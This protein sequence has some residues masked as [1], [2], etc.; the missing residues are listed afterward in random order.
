MDSCGLSWNVDYEPL[1][2]GTGLSVDS[3]KALVRADTRTILGVA[4][5]D[6]RAVQ[7]HE[8]FSLVETLC[9][10]YSAEFVYGRAIDGGKQAVVEARIP[11][12]IEPKKGDIVEQRI[13]VYNAHDYSCAYLG[14]YTLLRLVCI[15][16]MTRSEA[17]SSFRIRHTS[18]LD[19]RL[20]SAIQIM[21]K[22]VAYFASYAEKCKVLAQKIVDKKMVEKFLDEVIGTP[23]VTDPETGEVRHSVRIENKRKEVVNLFQNGSGNEGET[24]WDLY[25][26]LSEYADHF[27]NEDDSDRR[28]SSSLVG[29]N[30]DLKSRA[31]DVAL[32]L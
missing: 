10:H 18:G 26:G 30:A 23:M 5:K 6:Y 28:F 19:E 24:A 29:T 32:T 15:N 8:M 12:V 11:G 4:G 16:G 3:H 25:N 31:F 14:F 21:T 9:Q 13:T 20:K 7:P 22:G 27:H 17:S 2:T 1:L